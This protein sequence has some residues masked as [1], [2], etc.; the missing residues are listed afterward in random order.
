MEHPMRIK[1]AKK[2]KKTCYLLS[3]AL[4]WY[5]TKGIGNLLKFFL[6]KAKGKGASSEDLTH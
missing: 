2:K 1:I 3:L 5:K 6:H 4:F